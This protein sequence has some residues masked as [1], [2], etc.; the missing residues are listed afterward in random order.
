MPNRRELGYVSAGSTSYVYVAHRHL[1]SCYWR[2]RCAYCCNYFYCGLRVFDFYIQ[3]GTLTVTT[4]G[5]FDFLVLGRR[6]NGGS[7]LRRQ[8][9]G[10]GAGLV[11]AWYNLFRCKPNNYDWCWWCICVILYAVGN[12]SQAGNMVNY[13]GGGDQVVL[14]IRNLDLLHSILVVAVVAVWR[15]EWCTNSDY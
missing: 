7:V 1:R 6:F 2:Y 15:Y 4:A 9:G 3:T 14:R 11:V 13:C 10:G 5:L 12:I 8:C